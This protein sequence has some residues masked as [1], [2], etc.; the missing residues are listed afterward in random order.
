MKQQRLLW[1]ALYFLIP[2]I[3]DRADLQLTPGAAG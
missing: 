3:P 2:T 1:L